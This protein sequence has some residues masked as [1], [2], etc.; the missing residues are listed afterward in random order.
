MT[1]TTIGRTRAI[2]LEQIGVL[3]SRRLGDRGPHPTLL[4]ISTDARKT[5]HPGDA[6]VVD[7]LAGGRAVVE[8]GGDA[9]RTAGRVLGM[10][11]PDP[12]R[13]LGIGP[14]ALL[15]GWRRLEPGVVR[16]ALNLDKLTQSLHP[17][18]VSEGGG[19]VRDE[20]EATHQ[21]VSPAKYLAAR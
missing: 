6:L 21:R 7:P 4:R 2:P 17:A 5:Y 3:L 8:L 16:G 15:A 19:V 11:R 14:G 13:E 1:S 12:G 10:D 20:L 9:W 18:T